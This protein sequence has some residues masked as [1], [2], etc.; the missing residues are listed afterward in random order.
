MINNYI[1]YSASSTV[2]QTLFPL[3]AL[4]AQVLWV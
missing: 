3:A 1:S 4:S 2:R